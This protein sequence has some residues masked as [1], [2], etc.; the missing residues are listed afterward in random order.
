MYTVVYRRPNAPARPDRVPVPV[1]TNASAIERERAYQAS[2]E[3]Q[4][5]WERNW[6]AR[7]NHTDR[8]A[9]IAACRDAYY[10][11]GCG[12]QVFGPHGVEFIIY[13]SIREVVI[14]EERVDHTPEQLCNECGAQVPIGFA[15][16]CPTCK[17][18]GMYQV[19]TSRMVRREI[20]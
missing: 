2:F 13:C 20:A 3:P 9:A 11:G 15:A 8:G 17:T 6:N 16:P 18:T 7:E 5:A 14:E 10:A 19:Y 4:R 12:T 1:P